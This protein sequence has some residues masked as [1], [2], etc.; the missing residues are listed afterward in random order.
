MGKFFDAT[1]VKLNDVESGD[2]R[3]LPQAANHTI[4]NRGGQLFACVLW[5]VAVHGDN[6]PAIQLVDM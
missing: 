4:M 2:E 3:G 1:R 6:Q 5:K